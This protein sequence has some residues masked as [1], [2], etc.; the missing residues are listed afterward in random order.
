[1][2]LNCPVRNRSQDVRIEIGTA[3]QL[4]DITLMALAI[5]V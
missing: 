5:T 2:L 4:L 3:G 1:L